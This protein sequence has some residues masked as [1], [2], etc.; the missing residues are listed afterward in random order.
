M[1]DAVHFLGMPEANTALTQLTVYLAT[2]PKSN[3]LELAY[4]AAKDDAE[5]T[6][7]LK[8]PLSIRNAPTKVMKQP[9][10]FWKPSRG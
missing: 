8:V 9:S 10:P 5:K 4:Y 3:A 7:H 2:A 6:S 1:K